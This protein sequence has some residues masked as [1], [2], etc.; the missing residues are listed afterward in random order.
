MRL[1]ASWNLIEKNPGKWDFTELDWQ[2]AE[3]AK[4]GAKITLAIGQ[5]TPRWPECHTPDWAQKLSDQEFNSAL[6]DYVSKIVERY[7]NNKALEIWQ[8]ENEPFLPFGNYCRPFSKS[9]L[10]EEISLVKKMD[11][12]HPTLTTDSG[13]LS[14]WQDTARAADLFGTTMYRV[15]WNKTLG[16]V[17]YEWAPPLFYRSKLAAAGRSANTA[18][19]MELQAEPWIP[20]NDLFNVALAEQYK[21]MS[22]A[23]LDK[24][25]NFARRVGL[26]RAYLWGAEWWYWLK[27]KGENEIPTYIKHLPKN[28]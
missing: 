19:V 25:V 22:L 3:A 1:S 16:Y 7:R 14:F 10:T 18:Y 6:A 12:V 13:E 8:V 5:K 23:Q 17:N 20:D 11:P 9:Q 26:P 4:R 2:M 24:N 21:S 28:P 27:N 15:V